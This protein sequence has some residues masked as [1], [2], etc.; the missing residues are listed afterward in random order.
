MS[1]IKLIFIRAE[2]D[3]YWLP[4]SLTHSLTPWRLVNLID[5]ALASEDAGSK[6]V[7]VDTVAYA[8]DYD[9]VGNSLLQVSS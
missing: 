7:D 3:H 9:R 1:N 5:V 2:S 8:D 4:L 6:V